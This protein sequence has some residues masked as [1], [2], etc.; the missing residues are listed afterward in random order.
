MYSTKKRTITKKAEK[1]LEKV[2]S[3]LRKLYT[4]PC[5]CRADAELA[6]K[7][8]VDKLKLVKISED[9]IG[10]EE[11]QKYSHKG[12]HSK[13]EQKETVAVKVIA[14]ASLDEDAIEQKI[15]EDTYYVICTNDLDRKWT[16]AEL[17]GVYKK[18][19]VVERNWRCLKDKKLLINAI[20]LELPSRINALMWIMTTALLIYTATEYLMRK[21]MKEQRLSIPSPDHKKELEKPSLMRLYQYM[22]NSVIMLSCDRS[23]GKVSVLGLPTEVKLILIAMGDEWCQYYLKSYYQ[24][25]AF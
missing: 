23:T 11:V 1:E 16:M 12:R 21:K 9:D 18:Q 2:N 7:K 4:Q 15:K 3:N 14:E 10:Y 20:Y 19:S 25:K 6:V 8:I 13:D 5:K 22:G 17:I 24:D